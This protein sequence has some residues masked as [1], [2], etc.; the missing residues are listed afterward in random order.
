MT[1]AASITTVRTAH[2]SEFIPSKM[3]DTGATMAT[4]TKDPDLV[5]E[6]TLIQKVL[7][8]LCTK[9]FSINQGL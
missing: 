8:L 9:I 5:Y 3:L 4:L 7:F 2:G 6:I 1:S